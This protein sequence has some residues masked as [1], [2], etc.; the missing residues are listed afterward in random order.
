M[1]ET[2]AI[3]TKLENITL[4]FISDL[5]SLDLGFKYSTLGYNNSSFYAFN[6]SVNKEKKKKLEVM[7]RQIVK[8]SGYQK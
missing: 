8:P 5:T 2:S 1:C 4:Y 3:V 6:F 7:R